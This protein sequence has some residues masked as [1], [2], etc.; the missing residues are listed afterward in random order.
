MYRNAIGPALVV[1]PTIVSAASWFHS[2]TTL[3]SRSAPDAPPAAAGACGPTT[4]TAAARV[5][6]RKNGGV[7]R[8]DRWRMTCTSLVQTAQQLLAAATVLAGAPL[9]CHSYG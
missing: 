5:R 8:A 7:F 4:A 1:S 9:C 2:T 3:G 6:L